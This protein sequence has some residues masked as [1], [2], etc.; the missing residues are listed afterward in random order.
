MTTLLSPNWQKRSQVKL[1]LRAWVCSAMETKLQC[2]TLKPALEDSRRL[3]TAI[4][5][6]T[7]FG[8]SQVAAIFANHFKAM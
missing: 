1:G 2:V 7:A 3:W 8:R 6:A 5:F 4:S